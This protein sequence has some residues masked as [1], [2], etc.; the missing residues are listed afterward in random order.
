MSSST[1]V[2]VCIAIVGSSL[3]GFSYTAS[4]NAHNKRSGRRALSDIDDDQSR[5]LLS[6]NDTLKSPS[7]FSLK[8]TMRH[9]SWWISMGL[10][11]AGQLCNFIAYGY[12]PLSLIAPLGTL[13][14]ISGALSG[15][16]YLGEN[17]RL[18]NVL[19]MLCAIAGAILVVI[20]SR[21]EEPKLSP[22]DI[23]KAMMRLPFI[24]Y[25]ASALTGIIVLL[26]LDGLHVGG[27]RKPLGDRFMAIRVSLTAL[28][29]MILVECAYSTGGFTVLS[30]KAISS[31]L[32]SPS[33]MFSHWI[34][35]I[36]L[37]VFIANAISTV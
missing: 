8:D 9:Q 20:S 6:A 32:S 29:S 24:I 22:D 30:T 3:I 27:N 18:R 21:D 16:F 36:I 14:I 12:A 11:I 35:Y 7:P 33:G 19:G 10:L 31:F 5:P 17:I 25:C 26:T 23:V 13:S 28:F 34:T 37:V 4:K 1:S 15:Y 2:G